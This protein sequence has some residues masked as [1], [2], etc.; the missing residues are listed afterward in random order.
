[1]LAAKLALI[2]LPALIFG[3][4]VVLYVVTRKRGG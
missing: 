3:T 1:M 2:V 4:S